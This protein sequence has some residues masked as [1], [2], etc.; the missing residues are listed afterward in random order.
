MKNFIQTNCIK[1]ITSI[2]LLFFS[3][4]FFVFSITTLKA[5]DN[6]KI[7]EKTT[8]NPGEVHVAGVGIQ[9]G[10]AYIIDYAV[11]GRNTYYKIPLSKF[12]YSSDSGVE[13]L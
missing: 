3:L 4:G 13:D 6:V 10:Y 7:I 9:D 12:K 8:L 1:L 11:N 5:K 2:S